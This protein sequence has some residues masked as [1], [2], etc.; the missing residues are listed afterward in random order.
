MVFGSC[1][2][3]FRVRQLCLSLYSCLFIVYISYL[4]VVLDISRLALKVEKCTFYKTTNIEH[5]STMIEY[6]HHHN[7][8]SDSDTSS[9]P[10]R[11]LIRNFRVLFCAF[12]INKG[13]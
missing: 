7:K 10:G 2:I 12:N 13:C 6:H 11:D 3:I 5:D 8:H 1:V 4:V 9:D